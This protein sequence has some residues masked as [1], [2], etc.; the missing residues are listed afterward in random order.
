MV[1]PGPQQGAYD[2]QR[3]QANRQELVERIA[4]ATGGDGRV[5]P[6]N[7]LYLFRA[8]SPTELLHSVY[9]PAFCVIARAVRKSFLG[10]SAISTT[11][12]TICLQRS[13]CRS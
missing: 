5:E 13:S 2:V 6:L 7:G 9:M 1:L 12:H 8:S 4:Q 10:R 11:R 3:A